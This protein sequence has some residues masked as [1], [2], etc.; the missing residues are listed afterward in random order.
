MHL[1]SE[2]IWQ[3]QGKGVGLYALKISGNGNKA[4][5]NQTDFF[6]QFIQI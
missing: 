4:R 5:T 6:K 1:K 2:I 3:C